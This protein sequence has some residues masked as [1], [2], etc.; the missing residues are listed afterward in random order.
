MSD[1]Y[2]NNELDGNKHFFGKRVKTQAKFEDTSSGT[3]SGLIVYFKGI[4]SIYDI[5]CT[6]VDDDSKNNLSTFNRNEII[7]IIGTVDELSNSS[8][9]FKDCKIYK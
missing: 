6:S 2:Y 9:E 8:I 1:I 5:H 3:L 7:N 4:D